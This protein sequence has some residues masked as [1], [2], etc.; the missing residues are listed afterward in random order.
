MVPKESSQR[1]ASMLKDMY[2]QIKEESKQLNDEKIDK[3][4]SLND[5]IANRS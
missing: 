5:K 1:E 3:L 2:S 4:K